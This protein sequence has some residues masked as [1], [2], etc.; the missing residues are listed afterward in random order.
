MSRVSVLSSS[1]S[2][3]RIE[4]LT[5]QMPGLPARE[6]DRDTA[7]RWMK[8]GHS[9]IPVVKGQDAHAL[10]LVE[11]PDDALYVRTDGASVAQ[12]ALP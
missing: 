2:N 6:I 12:D 5:V 7:V 9:F 10:H 8:D 3:G 4:R 1:V 11:G